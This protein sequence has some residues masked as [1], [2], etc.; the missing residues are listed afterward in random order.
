PLALT[1][2][3]ITWYIVRS[4]LRVLTIGINEYS[5]SNLK[6]RHR[7]GEILT[8]YEERIEEEA[9]AQGTHDEANN[10]HRLD[11]GYEGHIDEGSEDSLFGSRRDRSGTRTQQANAMSSAGPTVIA[12]IITTASGILSAS[13]A[14]A[15]IIASLNTGMTGISNNNSSILNSMNSN[16]NANNS[17]NTHTLNLAGDSK[18]NAMSRG[19]IER[20]ADLAASLLVEIIGVDSG[21]IE[22]DFPVL[23]HHLLVRIMSTLCLPKDFDMLQNEQINYEEASVAAA[24]KARELQLMWDDDVG[25]GGA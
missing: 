10:E 13:G 14:N 18:K 22:R 3:L 5:K 2:K 20:K 4:L 21:P 9:K 24:L 6:I 11:Y 19:Q 17:G 25:L 15:S 12:P 1:R 16:N 23:L 8:R 7:S